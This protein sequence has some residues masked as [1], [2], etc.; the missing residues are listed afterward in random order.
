MAVTAVRG[1]IDLRSFGKE[2]LFHPDVRSMMGR[3]TIVASAELD[4]HFPKYWAGRV[5]VR[6]GEETYVEQVIIPKGDPGNPMSAE[7]ARQKFLSL[8]YPI[9]G[10]QNAD[11]AAREADLLEQRGSLKILLDF[12]AVRTA[13]A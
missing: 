9:I 7:D 13:R 3:V 8:A 4:N 6:S 5:R 12:L 11:G 1:N 2:F 10:A